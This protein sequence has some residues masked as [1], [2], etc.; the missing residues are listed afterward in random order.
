MKIDGQL[1]VSSLADAPGRARTM[2][3]LGFDGLFTFEGQHDPFFPLLLAAEHTERMELS[4]SVAIALARSP[5]TVANIGYDLHSYS[6]GRFVLGL[7]S[8]IRPHIEKR[9][10]MPWSKPVARMREY[11]LALRAIWKCWNEDGKLDFDGEFYKHT[12]MTPVF[13]PGP[14]SH[15]MPRIVLAGVGTRMTEVAAEVGDGLIVHPFS[16]EKSLAGITLP[17]VQAGLERAGRRRED[18]ELSCQVLAITG[19]TEESYRTATETIRYQI[20]FYGS[21]PAYRCVLEAEGCGE[22][23]TELNK[24]SKEG[25]WNDMP[26]C[27]SDDLR[28]RIANRGEPSTI[29]GRIHERYAGVADRIA[30]ASAYAL[31]ED[32]IAT[33][34]HGL[35]DIT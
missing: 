28:D 31:D 1:L 21:T 2:E 29:A 10:S 7:G 25:R 15:G 22:I 12:L 33:I 24:L 3:Q 6:G 5:M 20:A 4:T 35:K 26:G 13:N 27:V 9:F 34:V 18:F 30:L 32:S 23:Q 11:A 19:T 16:T 8:Q 14:N 17:A